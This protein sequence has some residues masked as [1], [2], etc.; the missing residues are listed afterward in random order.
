MKNKVTPKT[1]LT[2]SNKLVKSSQVLSDKLNNKY[3]TFFENVPVALWIED[4]SK[5]KKHISSLA[6]ENNTSIKDYLANHPAVISKLSSLVEIKD[7]NAIAVNLYKAKSKAEL[8]NNLNTVFTKKSIEGFSKLIK[9]ILNK[10]NVGEIESINKTLEGNE[11]NVAIKFNVLSGSEESLENVIVSIEDISEKVR[12]RTVLFESEKRYRQAQA[13]AKIGSWSYK[14]SSKKTYWSDEVYKIL[15][16]NERNK[17]INLDFYLSFVHTDDRFLV[18]NFSIDFLLKNQTQ[19]LQYRVQ[20][21]LGELKY[22]NEKRSVIVKDEKIIE[23]IGICQDITETVINEKKLNTTKNLFSNTLSSIKDGFVILDYNSNYLYVNKEAADL[24]NVKSPQNLIGK[25]IWTEFPE[26]EGDTFFDNYHK[27]LETRKP[28][29]FENYFKPW[30]RWFENRIIP[31]NEGMLLFFHEITDK[32][33][34]ENKIKEAYNI[35]NKSSTIAI[36]CKNEWDFPIEFVSEN[37]LGLFGYTNKELLSNE[38]KIAELVHPDD[39]KEISNQIFTILKDS[40]F[41]AIRPEPFRIITKKGEI[42]WVRSNIDTVRNKNNEITHIQGIT[43]DYTEQKYTEDLLFERSQR[44]K[45]QFNNTPLASIMWDVD[46]KIVEWNDAAER[47]FGYTAEE[48]KGKEC[49]D[50]LTPP[51]L[52]DHM[53]ELRENLFSQE[54]GLKNTNE[55]ITKSGEIIICDWYSVVLRDVQNN[56]VGSACLVDDITDRKKTENLLFESNQRFTDQFNNTPLASI[57]WDVDFNVL[58]WNNSAQRIFGYSSEEAKIKPIKDLI[59]PPY[60]EVEMKEMLKE[61]LKQKKAFRNTN[62]NVTKSGELITCDWYNVILKDAQGNLTGVASLVDDITERVKSKELLQK[63]EQ[64]YRDIFE[65]TIDAVLIIK[66]GVFVDCNASTL[67]M[68]GYKDKASLFQLHPSKISPVKQN[69]GINSYIKAEEMI[70]IAL[71]NGSNRF[72][73]L[74]KRK[75]GQVFPAEVSLT[76]IDDIDNTDRIHSVV[77]DITERVKKEQLED[78]LYNISKAAL[79]INDFKKFGYFIKVELEQ[80]IDTN[81]FYIAIYNEETDIITTPVFVDE[82]EDVEEF[83]AENSLTGYVI[84]SKK[85]LLLTNEEHVSLIE[86]G[87]VSLVGLPTE[88]WLGVPLIIKNKSI[89]AIVVQSYD[90]ENAYNENDV[91][92]LEFVADQISTTIQRKKAENELTV[93]L[94]KAQ[95]SDKLKSSFLANMSHE[96]RTPMNG[97]IGFS[98]LFLEPNLTDKERNNYAQVV[99]NSSKQL[100]SIVNDILDIS[101]IEAGVV[102]LDYEPI[103]LNQLLDRMYGFYNPKALE[104][105]LELN[106]KKG[107]GDVESFI[108]IDQTKLSQILTNL[109]S[110]AFKFTDSGSIKF[111]YELKENYLQF[112][113]KDTGVGIEYNLQ[114]KIFDR[115]IQANTHLSKKLQGTGL[116]LS[117]SKKFVELFKG[118]IWVDPTNTQG[119]TIFFTIPYIKSAKTTKITSVF[120]TDL[121]PKNE[122]KD[123]NLTILVAEDEE[124]N[125]MYINELFSKTNFN[126]I[127]AENGKKAVELFLKNPEIDLVLMD[128]KM[129]IMDGNEAMKIIKKEKPLIPVVALSAF[130]M[131]SDKK[132]AIKEGFDAYLTKPIDRKLLFNIIDKYA[133]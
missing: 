22:I 114:N 58:E 111:G 75:N 5:A 82:K 31:S 20:S 30:N 103:N 55:N 70:K 1:N 52:L 26:K 50:L 100:L 41:E 59:T 121:K 23:V 84:K 101:K 10:E 19:N 15:G 56:I 57:I 92:L 54:D 8:L 131:E 71:E 24:L 104:N 85:P 45:D 27:A 106:C 37:A 42:K 96:I 129:P 60:L 77:E 97:I 110:N 126:I 98:E 44:L 108:E 90:N 95:E 62:E 4:F 47:I 66:D 9:A 99:I 78:V 73:W 118:K 61:L 130:A 64:K 105:N 113:V 112:F 83:Y 79:T 69:N 32:K 3:F 40:N 65:K 11:F 72:R 6:K 81:N 14:F 93:A 124:Y 122:V 119:T 36:L 63:S 125:M 102:Q 127:E 29:R 28:I 35:I 12:A 123:L 87:E 116:G 133:N 80:I 46:F 109:L 51:H 132:A 39:L 53:K 25:H 88:C 76:R 68:F 89:G 13:I 7:V 128:I 120:E 86:K 17:E 18:N 34:S 107:L 38:L 91:Q 16:V 67:K 74:H 94:K 48:V 43:E 49:K 115:F 33:E 21:N 117:I 2:D